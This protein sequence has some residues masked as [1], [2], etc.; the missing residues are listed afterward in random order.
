LTPSVM[1]NS[2]YSSRYFGSLCFVT[3]MTDDD[4]GR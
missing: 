3:T 2:F 4:G 1:I